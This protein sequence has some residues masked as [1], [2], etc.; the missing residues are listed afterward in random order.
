MARFRDVRGPP[1]I[2]SECPMSLDPLLTIAMP[3]FNEALNLPGVLKEAL[4]VLD[5]LEGAGEV[6][7]VD[8]GS[9]DET[10]TILARVAATDSRL[11]WVRN[12]RNGG[13]GVFNRRMLDEAC[14]HWVFFIG[15]D[16]E[17]D[18]IEALRMLSTAQHTGVDGVLGYRVDKQYSRY[19]RLVSAAFNGLVRVLFGQR[20]VDIGSVRLLR[21][22]AY[23]GLPLYCRS[24]L[25][26]AERL[27]IGSRKG[28]RVVQVPVEHRR[29]PTGKGRGSSPLK[30]LRSALELLALR[31]RV[32][33]F[34]KYYG[35]PDHQ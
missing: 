30:V 32:L 23:A 21:R 2:V 7:V 27:I 19:R 22:S 13:I 29:R 10:P 28:A 24:A 12:Q 5:E 33:R 14:G 6:L 8:D 4:A 35:A 15:S 3:A 17:W 34:A 11:R 16:G 20:F 31:Y 18:C 26:N 25:I 1:F 9:T